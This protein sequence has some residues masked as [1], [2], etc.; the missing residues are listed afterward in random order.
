MSEDLEKKTDGMS[1]EQDNENGREGYRSSYSNYRPQQG[2]S[3]RPRIHAQR[4]YSP[5][6]NN[7]DS[8]AS[9]CTMF[10]TVMPV[11]MLNDT[12]HR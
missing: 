3:P 7:S 4:A 11:V 1:A 9:L 2:R 10:F 6:P 12:L 5:R 8:E